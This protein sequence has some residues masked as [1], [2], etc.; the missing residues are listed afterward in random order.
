MFWL[1]I[2]K[3]KSPMGESKYLATLTLHLLAIPTSNAGS[4]SFQFGLK[5]ED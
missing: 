3:M 2:L 1:S 5:D 4:E